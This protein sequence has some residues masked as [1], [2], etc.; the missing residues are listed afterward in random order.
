V[1]H[2]QIG[3]YSLP[4]LAGVNCDLHLIGIEPERSRHEQYGED[5]IEREL[6]SEIKPQGT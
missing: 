1:H 5:G 4:S 3:A 6:E 2:D